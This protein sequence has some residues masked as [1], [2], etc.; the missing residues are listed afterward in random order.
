MS[1][2]YEQVLIGLG[3]LTRYFYWAAASN[4][5]AAEST[6][7]GDVDHVG[8]VIRAHRDARGAPGLSLRPVRR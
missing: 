8:A 6:G 4:A 2:R 5:G 7:D 3:P 1:T